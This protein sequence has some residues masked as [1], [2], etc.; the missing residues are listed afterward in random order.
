MEI[1]PVNLLQ[2]NNTLVSSSV[3]QEQKNNSNSSNPDPLKTELKQNSTKPSFLIRSLKSGVRWLGIEPIRWLAYSTLFGLFLA[4]TTH[5]NV[6]SN[7]IAQGILKI[8]PTPTNNRLSKTEIDG[9]TYDGFF[10]NHDSFR[11]VL[12]TAKNA[13]INLKDLD[14]NNDGVILSTNEEVNDFKLKLFS[15]L[16]NAQ[17][18]NQRSEIYNSLIKFHELDILNRII[19]GKNGIDP[20]KFSQGGIPNCQLMAAIKAFSLTPENTQELKS[21]IEVTGYNF[22]KENFYIDTVVH[23]DGVDVPIPYSQLVRWMSPRDFDPSQSTDGALA[24]SMLSYAIDEAAKPYDT[25]PHFMPSTSPILLSGKD[26]LAVLT[27]TL[28][29][30]DIRH[31]LSQ[32]PN[33]PI[34]VGSYVSPEER[35]LSYAL[36]ELKDKLTPKPPPIISLAKAESFNQSV[37]QRVEELQTPIS[38]SSETVA[39][40]NSTIK[41]EDKITSTSLIIPNNSGIPFPILQTSSANEQNTTTKPAKE[42][43]DV[44]YQH[45]YTVKSYE[46]VG[47]EDI[48]IL[49][50][51]H[52]TEYK[53]INLQEFRL[54]IANVTAPKEH[55]PPVN[56]TTYIAALL[57]ATGLL[58]RGGANKLNKLLNPKYKSWLQR[59]MSLITYPLTKIKKTSTI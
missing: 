37:I 31:I 42:K 43:R 32:A 4:F 24:L 12:K 14:K 16:T 19:F 41:K 44:I 45:Q 53:P 56:S 8:T 1:K 59:T 20:E 48:I 54:L 29:D 17:N 33:T 23:L 25:I 26:Y 36:K 28:D 34:T 35:T 22:N 10:S 39:H 46:R 9:N 6:L 49:T 57:L 58:I 51:S 47:D 38:T 27:W 2:I 18:D 7:R 40:N 5:G 21:T 3:T 30:D 13:G 55:L 52:G 50:D 15:A 11:D